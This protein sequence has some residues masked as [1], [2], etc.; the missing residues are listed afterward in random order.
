MGGEGQAQAAE[1]F[2]TLLAAKRWDELA[3]LMS[4]QLDF[5]GLTPGRCWEAS[6]GSTLVAEVLTDW[7]AESDHILELLDHEVHATGRRTAVH[8]R[9]RVRNDDGDH[10]V[11][12]SGFLD[13]DER[14]RIARMSL[15]CGGYQPL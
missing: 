5:K 1:Q 3:E 10:L 8:Y 15:V 12:Q 9:L 7:F 2:V 11:E 13:V 14:G 4:P 6:D